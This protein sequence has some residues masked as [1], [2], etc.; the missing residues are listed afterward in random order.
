MSNITKLTPINY[1]MW[2]LQVHALLDGYGL[3][4][5]LDGSIQPPQATLTTNNIA[6]VNPDFTKWKR[7][8]KLIYSG[9]LGVISMTIQPTLSRCQTATEIWSKL[10][11]IYAI[12]S[13]GH[14]KQLKLQLKQWTKGTKTIDN[15]LQGLTTRFD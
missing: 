15:Y 6:S 10:A 4:G 8:V 13:R 2:S 5:Y 14:I 9:L 1:L 7:Q 3:A 12:P 11:V